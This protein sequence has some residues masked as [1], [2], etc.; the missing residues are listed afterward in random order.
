MACLS[1]SVTSEQ[2]CIKSFIHA[3]IHLFIQ[4]YIHPSL[5][6][7]LPFCAFHAFFAHLQELSHGSWHGGVK[8][9]EVNDPLTFCLLHPNPHTAA[10][11]VAT[12]LH[13]PHVRRTA[14]APSSS[15]CSCK[16][17]RTDSPETEQ[18]ATR[19]SHLQGKR[20]KQERE[21]MRQKILGRGT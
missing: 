9:L 20:T 6:G 13:Q 15:A 10:I 2:T 7:G 11:S 5:S 8:G 18:V 12:E 16:T 3:F 14:H 19:K 1:W 4:L 21:D 17:H